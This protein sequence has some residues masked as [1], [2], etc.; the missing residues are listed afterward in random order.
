MIVT[1]QIAVKIFPNFPARP[2]L[3]VFGR[4]CLPKIF[5]KNLEKFFKIYIKIV[6]GAALNYLWGRE[7]G[8]LKNFQRVEQV[9]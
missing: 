6:K 7:G 4:L 1:P 2:S 8:I 3:K 9:R 5:I